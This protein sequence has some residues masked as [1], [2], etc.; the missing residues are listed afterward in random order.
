MKKS[1]FLYL[2]LTAAVGFWLWQRYFGDETAQIRRQ[3]AVIEEL[4]EKSAGEGALDGVG[5]A[6]S[7]AELFAEPFSAEVGPAGQTVGDRQQLMQ[8]F[9]VFRHNSETVSLD[10]RRVD[11][12]VAENRREAVASFEALLNGGP[13]GILADHAYAVE[14]RFRKLSGEWKISQASVTE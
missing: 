10:Y 2:L 11:I 9:V 4:V 14:L 1:T 6:R 13:G 8:L 5:R 7:F 3:L 12:A